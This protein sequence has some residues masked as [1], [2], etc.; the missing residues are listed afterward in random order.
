MSTIKYALHET[1]ERGYVAG[2]CMPSFLRN[3]V[4]NE[5]FGKQSPVSIY[6]PYKIINRPSSH[7]KTRHSANTLQDL[8]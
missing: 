5:I 4:S 6:H 8:N 7:L 3:W 2:C 1:I